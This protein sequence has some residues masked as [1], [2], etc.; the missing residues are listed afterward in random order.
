[1]EEE[2][3][4]RPTPRSAGMVV[5]FCLKLDFGNSQS[6]FVYAYANLGFLRVAA[7]LSPRFGAWPSPSSLATAYAGGCFLPPLRG[8]FLRLWSSAGRWCFLYGKLGA[9]IGL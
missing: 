9:C 8:W 1:M 6:D 7:F 3:S 4:R 5:D 2:D